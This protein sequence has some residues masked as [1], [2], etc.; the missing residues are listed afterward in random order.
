MLGMP[1]TSGGEELLAWRLS[2]QCRSSMTTHLRADRRRLGRATADSLAASRRAAGAG[3][4]PGHRRVP[5]ST[6]SRARRYGATR[7]DLLAVR[8]DAAS[9]FARSVA[10]HPSPRIAEPA[11]EQIDE[12]VK[13][14]WRCRRTGT[15]PSSHVPRSP[16]RRLAARGS[17]RDLPMPA[18]ADEEDRLAPLQH[19]PARS[20]RRS[21]V[22]SRSRPTNG[23][24]P[25][26]DSTSRRVRVVV[27]ADDLARR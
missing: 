5:G 3:S 2:T 24:R 25:R 20:S 9:I 4:W 26:S 17:S 23:V 21:R 1:S 16:M 10:L 7:R 15:C 8:S 19:G 13:A 27:L 6:E 18:S 12:R 11:P 14:P 22:S